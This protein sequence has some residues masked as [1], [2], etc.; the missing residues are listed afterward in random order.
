MENTILIRRNM[1]AISISYM[2]AKYKITKKT[3][4]CWLA[5]GHCFSS[6]TV[7][8]RTEKISLIV[9]NP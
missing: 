7:E 1:Y 2:C 9:I 4:N 5:S 6:G 3:T 8:R